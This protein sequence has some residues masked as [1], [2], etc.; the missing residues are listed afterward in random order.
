ML[1]LYDTFTRSARPFAP[2]SADAVTMYSCGPTVYDDVH[3]GNLRSFAAADL[4]RRYLECRGFTVRQIMNITDV[5]HMLADADEGEDKMEVAAAKQ[6]KSPQE[7]AAFY[8]ERFFRDIDRL[9]VSRAERY[10]KASE[11]VPQMI[12]IIEQL[13]MEGR[14]YKV[15]M[16]VYYDVATF[17]AY[18]KLSGNTVEGL[19]AG[20]RVE[21]RDEKKHP[22]D[23]AL[24]IHNPKHLQQWDAP[25]GAGYPGW[26]IECSAMSMEYLGETIDLHTGGEDNKFPHHECEIAQSE[27]ATGKPFVGTWMHVT[28]LLVDGEKMSKSKGNFFVLEDLIAKGYAAREVRYA[29]IAAHYR[30]QLNFTFEGLDAARNALARLDEFID[31]LRASDGRGTESTDAIARAKG[32]FEEAMDDDLNVSGALAAVFEMVR[33]VNDRNAGGELSEADRDAALDFMDG[34]AD[35]LGVRFG[36]AVTDEDIPAE[37]RALVD[38]R[39]AARANKDW[40]ESDRLRDELKAKGYAVEDTQYGRR[41]KRI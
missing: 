32:A 19:Q 31:L 30:Q 34:V 10:P 38:A 28:H 6:G 37:V 16:N 35:V 11:H 18:G 13:L 5:G 24:W 4:L 7:V 33:S 9:G 14:A 21:V 26:H 1:R 3:I 27:G 2:I 20:A 29:L 39:D 36:R 15:G 40:K 23:F 8:T 12:R 41:I 22:A 25:W 17:P